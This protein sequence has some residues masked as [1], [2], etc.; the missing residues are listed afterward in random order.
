MEEKRNFKLRFNYY[1][2]NGVMLAGLYRVLSFLF[3][4]PYTML[5]A[6]PIWSVLDNCL[7]LNL[8]VKTKNPWMILLFVYLQ[9][10]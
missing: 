8:P 2:T 9:A 5:L 1:S 4:S 6:V 3:I 10:L 7:F